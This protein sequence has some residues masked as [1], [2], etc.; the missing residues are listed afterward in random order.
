MK[1]VVLCCLS[2]VP[3]RCECRADLPYVS[4]QSLC[5]DVFVVLL[6]SLLLVGCYRR[7]RA[8]KP[9]ANAAGR[10][11]FSLMMVRFLG[12]YCNGISQVVL[13]A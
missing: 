8:G 6:G 7:S 2:A 13:V 10:D 4:E 11:P 3:S 9:D 5:L 1:R 12:D